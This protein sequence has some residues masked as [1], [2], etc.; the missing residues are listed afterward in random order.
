VFKAL[1]LGADA[2]LL[3]RPLAHG[4]AVAGALGVAHVL[5]LLRED[6]ELTLA[7]AGCPRLADIDR[8][9]LVPAFPEPS[10]CSP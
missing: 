8:A 1:A 10:A 6:L 3:G 9:C 4:L 5:R 7:L 2:V